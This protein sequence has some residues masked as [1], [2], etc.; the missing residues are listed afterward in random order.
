MRKLIG[1]NRLQ[2]RARRLAERRRS[3]QRQQT[4]TAA[5]N[6]V[7]SFH[8][9]SPPAL[10]SGIAQANAAHKVAAIAAGLPLN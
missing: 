6:E 5:D 4:G 10:H 1:S 3:T 9:E 8:T 7:S 2:A